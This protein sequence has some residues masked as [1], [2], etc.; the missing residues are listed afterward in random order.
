M[1]HPKIST[2]QVLAACESSM[3]GLTDIG[4]C[5]A[6]GEEILHVEKDLEKG[7]CEMCEEYEVYGCEQLLLRGYGQ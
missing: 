2:D 6:C 3:F 4:F 1:E 7:F 5:L